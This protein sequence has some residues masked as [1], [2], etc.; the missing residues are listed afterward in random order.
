VDAWEVVVELQ[1]EIPVESGREQRGEDLVVFIMAGQRYALPLARVER[2]MLST[3]VT[4]LNSPHEIIRGSINLGNRIIPV[5]DLRVRLGHPAR[6]LRLL[7]HLLVTSTGRRTVALLVDEARGII[8]APRGYGAPGTTTHLDD[9][10]IL[11]H[12]LEALLSSRV[13]THQR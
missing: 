4:R 5:I 8:E 2:S 10:L 11:I 9:G 7:D 1:A 6:E 12:D 13:A 3:A